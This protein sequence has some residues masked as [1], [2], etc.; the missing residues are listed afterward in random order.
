MIFTLQSLVYRFCSG[1]IS[2]LVV[3]EATA[4]R[5]TTVVVRNNIH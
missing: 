5:A 1:F 3:P 2:Q 4:K